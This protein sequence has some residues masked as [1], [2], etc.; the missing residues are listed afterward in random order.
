MLRKPGE[1]VI[2]LQGALKE[3]TPEKVARLGLDSGELSPARFRGTAPPSA[4]G[5]DSR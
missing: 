5:R 1:G 2:G 4:A 3:M